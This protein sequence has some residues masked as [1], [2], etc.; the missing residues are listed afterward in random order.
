MAQLSVRDLYRILS[1]ARGREGVRFVY[2]GAAVSISTASSPDAV[3]ARAETCGHP[4]A[5]WD[6]TAYGAS[7]DSVRALMRMLDDD[8]IVDVSP[9]W[10]D[11]TVLVVFT[12]SDWSA[13]FPVIECPSA[14]NR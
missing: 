14:P 5:S 13:P 9:F 4:T 7:V 1:E 12:T 10:R 11:T 2:D 8:Q 3:I 6:L